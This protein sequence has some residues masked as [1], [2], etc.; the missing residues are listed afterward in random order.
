[1]IDVK[2]EDRWIQEKTESDTGWISTVA[3]A[4]ALS[5]Y[6]QAGKHQSPHIP[7]SLPLKCT[8]LYEN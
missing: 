3:C 4:S 7:H 1:M 6:H 8:D 5:Y 2:M